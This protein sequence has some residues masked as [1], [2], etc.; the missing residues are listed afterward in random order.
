MGT[1]LIGQSGPRAMSRVVAVDRTVCAPAPTLHLN[2]AENLVTSPWALSNIKIVRQAPVQVITK[3]NYLVS[4]GKPRALRLSNLSAVYRGLHI[5]VD[6]YISIT[7]CLP[8]EMGQDRV[9]KSAE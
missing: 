5:L 8:S 3:S 4:F 2:M 7:R 9:T 1:G 6:D